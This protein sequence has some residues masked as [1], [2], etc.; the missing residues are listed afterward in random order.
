MTLVEGLTV[1]FDDARALD[2]VTV[3][4]AAGGSVVV[5][6]AAG[7]GK[8]TLARTVVGLIPDL[9]PAAVAGRVDRPDVVG[10]VPQDAAAALIEP[11][12]GDDVGYGLPADV[13]ETAVAAALA[14]VG[15]AGFED[16]LT[17]QLSGGQVQRVAIAGALARD[18]DLVVLDD[19]TS[20]LDAEGRRSVLDALAGVSSLVTTQDPVVAAAA[21]RVIVL[22]SG[23]VAYDGTPGRLYVDADRCRGL[24]LRVPAAGGLRERLALPSA[25]DPG[26]PVARV[27]GLD[28][29][30][31]NGVRA[32]SGADLTVARG[33]VV[34]L[35]GDNGSGKSTLARCLAG[36]LD[37]G[38]A[39][40]V[41]GLVAMV[42]Q[43][44]DAQLFAST[45]REEAGYAARCQGATPDEVR[46]RVDRALA[47]LGLAGEAELHPMRLSRSARQL[48]AVA[49]ALAAGP[50]LLIL[51]EP[52][53]GLDAASFDAVARAIAAAA[54]GGAAVL[55]VTHDEEL[56]S[57]ATRVVT[58]T[59]PAQ[60][61]PEAGTAR[62]EVA[63]TRRP[64]DPRLVAATLLVVVVALALLSSWQVLGAMLVAGLVALALTAGGASRLRSA[65]LPILPLVALIGVFGYLLPPTF[66]TNPL[67]YAA[68]LVLRLLAMLTWTLWALARFDAERAIALARASRLPT[69]LVLVVTIAVRFIPTLTARL[70]QIRQAQRSRGARLDGGPVQRTRSLL[71][72]LIPL[73]VGAIRTSND[74]AAA[75]VVRGVASGG[76]ARER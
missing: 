13:A 76:R 14:R 38:D 53:A 72:V 28:F 71:S 57:L 37:G 3:E 49:S 12:V 7:A 32:L 48:V 40:R 56:A 23:R 31:P 6:G 75:L 15:M 1:D 62:A 42:F 21:D 2:D 9:T 4:L 33:E 44:P 68:S 61:A 24:G 34:A 60:S 46:A 50:D 5:L 54:A 41:D 10:F 35:R 16:R 27:S 19:P 8:S 59:A 39:V 22:S 30:Y 58:L 55:L 45:V 29:T 11:R 70:D 26:A 65:L 63:P 51:D 18:A 47:A 20:E 73:F 74:L 36:L 43:D 25:A 66:A 52:T 67:A 64:W 17:G 69:Q